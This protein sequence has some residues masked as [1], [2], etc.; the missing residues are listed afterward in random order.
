MTQDECDLIGLPRWKFDFVPTINAWHEY[1]YN[2]IREFS[3][4][5][6]FD[7]YSNDATR[8]LGLSL[9]EIESNTDQRHIRNVVALEDKQ[10]S[11]IAE[12]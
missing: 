9:A 3:E 7:P 5:R 4:T 10:R 1:H 12:P 8:L 11:T 6:G 2:A